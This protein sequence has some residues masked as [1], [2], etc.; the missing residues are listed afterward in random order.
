LND[1]L[2]KGIGDVVDVFI[3]PDLIGQSR[4]VW[5]HTPK[6]GQFLRGGDVTAPIIES[7][8]VIYIL[9]E[10]QR[11]HQQPVVHRRGI[12]ETYP[13]AIGIRLSVAGIGFPGIGIPVDIDGVPPQR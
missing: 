2:S 4:G 6:Q 11:R 7:H 12:V 10:L 3:Y 8:L 1:P 9:S 5:G 13:G